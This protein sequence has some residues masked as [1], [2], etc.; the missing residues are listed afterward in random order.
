MTAERI[1]I[2]FKT[3]LWVVIVAL[4]FCVIWINIP[5]FSAFTRFYS[6]WNPGWIEIKLTDGSLLYGRLVGFQGGFIHLLDL[7]EPEIFTQKDTN[8]QRYWLTQRQPEIFLGTSKVVSWSFVSKD[9]EVLN[10]LSR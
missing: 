8:E 7:R 9:S 3:L 10:N 5:R 6:F 4:L 1:K 2:I